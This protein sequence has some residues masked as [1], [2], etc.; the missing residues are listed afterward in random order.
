LIFHEQKLDFLFIDGDQCYEGMK[1]DVVLY[2]LLV[3]NGS[4]YLHNIVT[5][6]P[7]CGIPQFWD[8]IKVHHDYM[9][10]VE[11][12]DQGIGVGL[13]QKCSD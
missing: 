9:E 3:N 10:I 1:K 5:K 11:D 7:G 2:S 4:I 8:E 12:P 13:W 6:T